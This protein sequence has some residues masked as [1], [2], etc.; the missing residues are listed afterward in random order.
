MNFK[1]KT[2]R[3]TANGLVIKPVRQGAI[4]NGRIDRKSS[5]EYLNNK[6]NRKIATGEK[7]IRYRKFS[8]LGDVADFKQKKSSKYSIKAEDKPTIEEKARK[9]DKLNISASSA[10]A[11]VGGS[12]SGFTAADILTENKKNLIK[13]RKLGFGL[14]GLGSGVLGGYNAYRQEKQK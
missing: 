2:T 9:V 11:A 8:L 1:V 5:P 7:K 13:N 14:V 4:K 3:N 6:V 12:A 10:L